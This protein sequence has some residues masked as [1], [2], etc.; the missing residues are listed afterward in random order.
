M[1]SFPSGNPCR[2][3]VT[4]PSTYIVRLMVGQRS[5]KPLIGVRVF[6]DV[7][8]DTTQADLNIAGENSY[9]DSFNAC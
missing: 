8:C 9:T 3:R 4:P 5:P 2:T 1:P 6:G 7:P